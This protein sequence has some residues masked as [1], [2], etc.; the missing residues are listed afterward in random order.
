LAG[1][2]LYGSNAIF[3]IDN[4]FVEV[5]VEL[6]SS[7]QGNPIP[8]LSQQAINIVQAGLSAAPAGDSGGEAPAET[9]EAASAGETT[10][11]NQTVVAGI[12]E[13]LPPLLQTSVEWRLDSATPPEYED[14]ENG[15]TGSIHYA[16]SAPADAFI[17][18]SAF[19]DGD[20]AQAF[21]D[22]QHELHETLRA[23]NPSDNFDEPNLFAG[24]TYGWAALLRME[25][26][27]I[28]LSVPRFPSTMGDPLPS[29]MRKV[30]EAVATVHGAA[31]T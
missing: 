22:A 3:Q 2:G 21:F 10:S 5:S 12:L 4:L 11:G 15:V 17:F 6:F 8:S 27:V 23:A 18:V 28:R 31:A 7:T 14:I 13:A 24:G 9:T 19:D 20:L 1:S 25:N 26:V 30:M 29:L 16:T